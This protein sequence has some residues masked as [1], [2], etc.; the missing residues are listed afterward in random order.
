M[1]L[2]YTLMYIYGFVWFCFILVGFALSSQNHKTFIYFN[3]NILYDLIL[4]YHSKTVGFSVIKRVL[5][6]TTI[7]GTTTTAAITATIITGGKP[8]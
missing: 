7:T 2:S 4:D 8:Q 5:T 1:Q 6:R 3:N